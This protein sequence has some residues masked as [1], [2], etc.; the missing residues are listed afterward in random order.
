[1]VVFQSLWIVAF[2]HYISSSLAKKKVMASPTN[3]RIPQGIPSGPVDLF[4]PISANL[5]LK[6]L[7]TIIK[8]SPKSANCIFG[9][10]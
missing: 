6:P 4:L 5:Y 2:F 3:F 8:A 1:M 10:L 9:M 7:V